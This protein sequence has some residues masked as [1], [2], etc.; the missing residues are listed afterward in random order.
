MSVD[1]REVFRIIG[2]GVVAGNASA[3]HEHRTPTVK[4]G[5]YEPRV[6]SREQYATLQRVLEILLPAD[7]VSPSAKDAGVGMYID[8]TLKFGDDRTRAMWTSGLAALE[9]LSGSAP[10]AQLDGA[11]ATSII[12]RLARNEAHP[13]TQSEK[14]FVV[15]KQAA[16]NA[17]YLSDGGRKSLAYTGDTA[18]A[19]FRGCTHPEHKHA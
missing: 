16:I 10:F 13:Q 2:A 5:D 11:A 3:Q 17:Y 1:R 8:T 9:T 18:I 12:A 19:E 14:F 4:Q 15:C 7:E 6:L